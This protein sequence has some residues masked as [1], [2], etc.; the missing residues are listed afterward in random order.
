[1]NAANVV[2]ACWTGMQAHPRD[3]LV[4]GAA[5]QLLV[6]FGDSSQFALKAIGGHNDASTVLATKCLSN[7][8][9]VLASH[10]IESAETLLKFAGLLTQ[11]A[12]TV[13]LYKQYM[14]KMGGA[15]IKAV[16]V[17]FGSDPQMKQAYK[18]VLQSLISRDIVAAAAAANAGAHSERLQQQAL[19][20]T[21]ASNNLSSTNGDLKPPA[22]ALYDNMKP[23]AS[24]DSDFMKPASS[25]DSDNMKPAASTDSD[26]MKATASTDSDNIKQATST[27]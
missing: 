22:S 8:L 16:F 13:P 17:N 26:N 9:G 20:S 19:E 12:V 6:A 27:V 25:T 1:L 24:T 14:H 18:Q 11:M 4:Q 3:A 5:V 23:A 10:G 21:L 7:A 2:G 15:G